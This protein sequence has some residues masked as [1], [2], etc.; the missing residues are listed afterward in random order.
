MDDTGKEIRE[1]GMEHFDRY[2]G[3]YKGFVH[4]NDDPDNLGRLQLLVPKVYGDEP[5]EEWAVS[6]GI[7][8]G[9]GVGSF[10]IPAKG[11]QVWVSFENG[12]IRFPIW[13]YGAWRT[14]EV[15]EGATKDVKILQTNS[16]QRIEF[17]DTDKLI[18]IKDSHGHIIELNENGVSIVSD[19][20]SLGS[21]DVS[22]EPAVLGDTAVALL[23]EFIADIGALG[24]IVT[25]SGVT[26]TISTSP[27]WAALVSKWQDKWKEFNSETVTL[28]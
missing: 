27:Q 26:S 2:Y 7:Y 15:P 25:S 21:L 8:A 23:N 1:L 22:A 18:R 3:T 12:D 19:T 13:E 28:D 4:S 9:A 10:W 6:K 11:D 20:I 16:G 17:N 14:G 24:T 5:Y